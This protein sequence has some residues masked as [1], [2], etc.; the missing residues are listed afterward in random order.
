MIADQYVISLYSKI[1][2][3]TLLLNYIMYSH[4]VRQP[5]SQRPPWLDSER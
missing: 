3:G 1:Y 2:G 5:E 4:V